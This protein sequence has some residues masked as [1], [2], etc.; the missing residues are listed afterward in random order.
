[1]KSVIF[2][3][4]SLIFNSF[5]RLLFINKTFRLNNLKNR[6]AMNVKI[7]VFVIC[8]EAIIY[9]LLNNLYDCTFKITDF[10][11]LQHDI[12][13]VTFSHCYFA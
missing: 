9:S 13:K 4:S 12:K 2:L 6:T 1:M 3:K 10:N 5:D 7:S 8:V 11:N